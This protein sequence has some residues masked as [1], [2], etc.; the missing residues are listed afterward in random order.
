[1]DNTGPDGTPKWTNICRALKHRNTP[2][3]EWKLSP[4]QLLFGRPVRDFLPVKPGLFKPSKVWLDCREKREL[5]MRHRL[6]FV[7]S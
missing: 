6:T 2:D 7:G 4:S 5:A 3:Q 1:M